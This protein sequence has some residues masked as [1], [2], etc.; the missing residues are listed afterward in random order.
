MTKNNDVHSA[1]YQNKPWANNKNNIW[2]ASTINLKRNLEKFSF[3][4]KLDKDRCSQII[5]LVSN[6]LLRSGDLQNPTL[7]KSADLA[8]LEKEYLVEHFL[9]SH[10][11]Q[12]AHSGEAFILDQTGKFLT[13]LNINNHIQF[14]LIDCHGELETAWNLLVKI[15]TKLGKSINYSFSSKFGF[16]TMDPTQCGTGLILTVF[17][18][19]SALIH[20]GKIE[21][22]L[23]RIKREEI[24]ITGLQGAPDEIIGDIYSAHNNFTLGLTEEN[25]ISSLRLFT[26]KL[27]VEENSTRTRLRQEENAEV[28]DMVSRAY[29]LLIHSYQIETIEALNA[30]SLLK[31]GADLGWLKGASTSELNQLFFNCRRAHLLS[32]FDEEIVKEEIPHKRAE[33]IHKT[34]KDISLT[35]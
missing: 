10:S 1:L 16:L 5:S 20:T 13:T 28:M 23:N 2:L 21:E 4:S 8:P 35:I 34:L 24:T 31:L 22:T 7:L 26:T 19:P 17:L 30:I 11:F 29:G 6:E 9:S 18:Q 15:E 14:E 3:P 33:F 12:Q 27:M 25:I 32:K